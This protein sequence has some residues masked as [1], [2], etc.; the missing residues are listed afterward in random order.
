MFQPI[1]NV[2][3]ES[4]SSKESPTNRVRTLREIYEDF[5]FALNVADPQTFEEA[6]KFPEW[7]HAMQEELNT[8]Q[9]TK[10]WDLT[11]FPHSKKKIGVKWVLET[12][13]KSNG[14]IQ[15]HKARLVA[16]SYTQGYGIDYE[17]S[18][19]LLARMDTLR[20]LLA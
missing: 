19:S 5:S 3:Q 8:I 14:E 9:R 18:F 13:Y 15:K 17:Q 6:Q 12:K 10:T 1:E 2:A 20:I 11:E 4:S 7:K 16:K